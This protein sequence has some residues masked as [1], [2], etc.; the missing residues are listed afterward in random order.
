MEKLRLGVIGFGNMGTGHVA[1]V[2]GGRVP[3][4]E[5]GAICDIS[6]ARQQAAQKQYPGIPVFSSGRN[7]FRADCAMRSLL[8]PPIMTIPPWLWKPSGMVSM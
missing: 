3:E 7:C 6:P 8:Q 5:M 2:A 4:M 1:S